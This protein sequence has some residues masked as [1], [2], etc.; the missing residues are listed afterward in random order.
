M[1]KYLSRE[2]IHL[3]S[4]LVM[5]VGLP[6][7]PFLMTVGQVL[8]VANCLLDSDILQKVK[9]AFT[10]RLTL[11]FLAIILLHFIGLLYTDNFD[12]AMRDLRVKIPLLSLPLVFATTKPLSEQQWR[13]LFKLFGITVLI[14]TIVSSYL[15]F[16]GALFE[17]SSVRN[18]SIFISH[19]RFSLMI[20]LTIFVFLYM[21]VFKNEGDAKFRWWGIPV[22]IWLAIFLVLLRS[23]TGL[24]ILGFGFA[25][26][27]IYFTSYIKHFPFRLFI[28]MVMLGLFMI[29]ASYLVHSYGRFKHR[30]NVN[31]S[32]LPSHTI[33]GTPYKHYTS[34]KAW[35]NGNFVYV[36]IAAPELRK[37]WN[38]RSELAFDGQDK[39]GHQ[40]RQTLIRYMASKGLKKD[41]VGLSQLTKEDINAIENG[42]SN[43]IFLNKF[44]I[45][46]SLYRVFWELERYKEGANPSG[47]SII[48]RLY[49]LNAGWN[50]FLQNPVF[51]VG[52]GDVPDAFHAYYEQTNSVLQDRW[53]LRTHN[54]YRG[55]AELA[56]VPG[57]CR[58]VFSSFF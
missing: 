28:R 21:A 56:G 45:Y 36:N 49:Y 18:I 6:L 4:I 3:F 54:Q 9:R 30:E 23:L 26:F 11:S 1:F 40:L 5:M 29:S 38:I 10:N 55:A 50:I 13:G 35:E 8:F 22:A 34:R 16:T 33:N 52:T 12:Y 43:H 7:S 37:E 32:E 57:R 44:S 42:I 41:S 51:G 48:Q 24:V 27:S 14:G 58:W 17:M 20:C 39:L 2:N 19:I 46:A 15:L 47:N 53:R 31:A 25:V